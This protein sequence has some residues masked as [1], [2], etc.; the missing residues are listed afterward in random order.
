MVG[1]K[2]KNKIL[3]AIIVTD[4]SFPNGMAA[5]NR[6]KC[7]S[8]GLKSNNI[9]PI[10]ISLSSSNNFKNDIIY[11]NLFNGIKFFQFYNFKNKRS[12]YKWKK[13]VDYYLKSFVLLIKGWNFFDNNSIVIYYGSEN[14]PAFTLKLIS[15]IK[16]VKIFKEET[17]H[18]SVRIE[19]KNTLSKYVFKYI[20]YHL[21][22]GLIVISHSLYEYFISDIRIKKPIIIVPI[23]L[24][25]SYF[26][27][28]NTKKNNSIVYTGSLSKSKEGIDNLII[29]MKLVVN[30]HPSFTLHLYGT[31]SNE[32]IA[33][34]NYLIKKHSLENNIFIKGYLSQSHLH[35]IKSE[36]NILISV[37]PQSIQAKYGLSTKMGE[38]LASGT[39]TILTL[40]GDNH[41][42]LKDNENTFICESNI[43][44]IANK[45]NFVIENYDKALKIGK[46]GQ[47]T[48]KKLFFSENSIS[49]FL[50]DLYQLQ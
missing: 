4:Q 33:C 40:V 44:S 23:L 13:G 6:I 11:A 49:K 15:I 46:K 34:Y 17:E 30:K 10:V 50:N 19:N 29:A 35:K 20:H 3:K 16:G 39:P 47:E 1:Y 48:A 31:G 24:D 21:F 41:L 42:Y 25:G 7:F 32:D 27:N 2:I 45:I 12:K 5:T 36:A 18:L 43:H 8:T 28:L 37:R 38:Y 14:L 9:E 26:Y 22:Y